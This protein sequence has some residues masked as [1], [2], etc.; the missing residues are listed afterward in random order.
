MPARGGSYG[1]STTPF[2][3]QGAAIRLFGALRN[4]PFRGEAFGGVGAG[5]DDG[6]RRSQQ[7]RAL[8]DAFAEGLLEVDI[9][10][11][12][13]FG[14]QVADGGEAGAQMALAPKKRSLP[15]MR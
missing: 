9:G 1:N 7:S 6:L 2:F 15:L 8:D 4:V 3:R 10:V 14:A 12:G 11:A 13:A 5:G